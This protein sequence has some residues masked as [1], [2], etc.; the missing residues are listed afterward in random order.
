MCV[1]LSKKVRLVQKVQLT[2]DVELFCLFKLFSYNLKL[3]FCGC[4]AQRFALAYVS[5]G[6]NNIVPT[7]SANT[8]TSRQ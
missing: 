8:E 2:F 6:Y 4:N 5:T 3:Y 1:C 7:K